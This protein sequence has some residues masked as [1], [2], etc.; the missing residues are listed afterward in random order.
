MIVADTG[1]GRGTAPRPFSFQSRE[2]TMRHIKLFLATLLL[3]AGAGTASANT[4]EPP[5]TLD[6]VRTVTAAEA[7]ALVDKGITVLD[8]RR[9]AAYLESRV[10]TA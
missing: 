9:K 3:L 4:G 8:V 6:G 5:P 2:V 1:H 10:P 7:K